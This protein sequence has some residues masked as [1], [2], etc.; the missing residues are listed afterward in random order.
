MRFYPDLSITS[1]IP[2]K[3]KKKNKLIDCAYEKRT[4]L[5]RKKIKMSK[6]ENKK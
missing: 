5:K 6:K 2:K 1:A 3:M 4:E